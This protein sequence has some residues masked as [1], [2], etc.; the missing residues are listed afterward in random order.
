MVYVFDDQGRH[1][2]TVDRHDRARRSTTFNYDANGRLSGVVGT[3]GELTQIARDANGNPT[4]IIAPG[5]ERTALALGADGFL[6]SVVSPAGDA[7][8]MVY[9]PDGLLSD[10]HGRAGRRA[11]VHL[12][13]ERAGSSRTRT[14]PA[15]PPRC[16][17]PTSPNGYE[18]STTTALGRVKHFHVT[19]QRGR[20]PRAHRHRRAR[21]RSPQTVTAA[22]GTTT[23]TQPDGTTMVTTLAAD[24]V[25]GMV[26]PYPSQQTV[27]TPDGTSSTTT[28]TITSPDRGN[29]DPVNASRVETL[30]SA[31][32]TWTQAWDG[33]A[34]TF[35]QVTPSVQAVAQYDLSGR[36]VSL[37]RTDIPSGAS[38]STTRTYDGFGLLVS[39]VSPAGSWTY[40]HDAGFRL[41][42]STDALGSDHQRRLRRRR[43]AL[44]AD[45]AERRRDDHPL[46]RERSRALAHLRRR[47]DA[48]HLRRRGQRALEGRGRRQPGG[49]HLRP[50]RAPRR[51]GRQHRGA[52]SPTPST[53]RA[54]GSA[55]TRSTR[56]GRCGA[57]S[58]ARSTRGTASPGRPPARA[59]PRPTPT[60]RALQ[61]TVTDGLGNQVSY[62][63]DANDVLTQFTD[64]ADQTTRYA[65]DDAQ[66]LQTVTDARGASTLRQYDGLGNYLATVSPDSGTTTFTHDAGGLATSRTD[67]RGV[68]TTYSHDAGGRITSID[69]ST[70]GRASFTYDEGAFGQGK[71]T[72]IADAT[73]TT[74]YGYDA[75][76]HVVEEDMTIG[77][78]TWTIA[79]TYNGG[80][81]IT[82]VA[83]LPGGATITYGYD[84]NG[85]VT[86]VT[87][88]DGQSS[89]TLVS[90]ATYLPFGPLAGMTFGNGVTL[91]K[92]FD[93]D[94]R[95][96]RIVAGGVLDRSYAYDAAGNLVSIA[97]AVAPGNGETFA[98]DA[99][100]R[101]THATGA[102]GDESVHLRRRRRPDVDRA[103]RRDRHLRLRAHEPAAARRHRQ[104]ERGRTPTT[105]AGTRPRSAP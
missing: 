40:T 68:T 34:R 32:E 87:A 47:D 12:R 78:Q 52:A 103:R 2:R 24:P 20:L 93:A 18:V 44:R 27:T 96:T 19:D 101:L 105:G 65:F 36:V 76:G 85:R 43:E 82:S 80:G 71:L 91:S 89:R 3:H 99:A 66:S 30:T 8:H 104:H 10:L 29:G 90:G 39:L 6:A 53:R 54:T 14:R 74:R 51:Q 94:Y 70:G 46:R 61:S 88:S 75:Q 55:R 59:R 81:W 77:G 25:W 45:R 97:D 84:A 17:G 5:G 42:S 41:A 9:T 86:Q 15:G 79:R 35:T 58:S 60:P 48:L 62:A 49:V 23:L 67:G 83:V 50:R 63:Y 33:N 56:A 64:G 37:V 7:A 95:P 98:Y 11:P 22:D 16:P 57:R 21:R 31:G 100:G 92:T 26:A 69:Y 1:V 13:R 38:Q 28:R 73:G 4:A 102:Y 72:G